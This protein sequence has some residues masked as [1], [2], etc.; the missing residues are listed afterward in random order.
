MLFIFTVLATGHSAGGTDLCRLPTGVPSPPGHQPQGWEGLT[1]RQNAETRGKGRHAG[2]VTTR[3]A[4]LKTRISV[5]KHCHFIKIKS[6]LVTTLLTGESPKPKRTRGRREACPASGTA[7]VW[8]IF[9]SLAGAAL[10]R[11]D[12][13]ARQVNARLLLQPGH[14]AQ[15]EQ[16]KNWG[17]QSLTPFLSLHTRSH[18]RA[19]ARAPGGDAAAQPA[20]PCPGS[21]PR[22]SAARRTRSF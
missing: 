16:P 4:V 14:P 13:K 21:E 12:L 8:S 11:R 7:A 15:R 17:W 6:A 2:R 3:E 22:L 1:Q 10:L 20:C 19:R 5:L 9:V 18:R